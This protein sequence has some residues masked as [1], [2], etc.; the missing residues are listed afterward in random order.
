MIVGA[1]LNAGV[2]L[3]DLRAQ[4][5]KLDLPGYTLAMER[6][7]R[8]GLAG[9]KFNV[10]LDENAPAA[11]T[12]PAHEHPHEDHNHNHEHE[13]EHP[14]APTEHQHGHRNLGDIFHLLDHA[15][16]AERIDRRARM[17]FR[18]L[19]EAEARAHGV[20]IDQ[21]HFHEVG[22]VD[23]I[24]DIVGAAIGL[25]LLG[26]ETIHCSPIPLGTGTVRSEHGLL[27]VP[28]PATAALMLDGVIAPSDFP[29]ELC[30]PTGAAI[31]TTL[32]ESFCPLPAMALQAIGYGAGGRDD[33]GRVNM[34]RV[35]LGQAG[36]DTQA[37][38]VV[39]LAA[40]IDDTSGQVLGAVIEMLLAAGALDA[41]T[42]P[43]VMKKSRPAV[44]VGV[45]CN[46]GDVDKLEEILFRQTTTI[47][48]RRH[49]CSRTKLARRFVTVETPY[50]PVRVKVSFAGQ[51][52]YSA[53]PEFDD[54]LQAGLTHHVPIK[55]VQLA[56]IELYRRA[57]AL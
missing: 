34:L 44:Q 9:I 49:T 45:L 35:F 19:G 25:E 10:N 54:C 7:T 43:I 30:T 23:S 50:G 42:A 18:R 6:V 33:P 39:E 57:K 20:S 11:E 1:L 26:V 56:A 36:P 16:L 31:L 3:E 48:I 4:L 52:E 38:T 47:G 28:A 5:R 12:G 40:N 32:A 21:V 8:G 29:K 41:W 15:K 51:T 27:P 17:I 55:E 46:P 37:D 14:A 22:A 2:R 13:H 24:V 53:T